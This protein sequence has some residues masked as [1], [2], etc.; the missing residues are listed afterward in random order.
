MIKANDGL[1][2][3]AIYVCDYKFVIRGGSIVV[4]G[5]EL[6]SFMMS[7]GNVGAFRKKRREN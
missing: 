4:F 2:S 3:F 5:K 7:W 6:A 1:N